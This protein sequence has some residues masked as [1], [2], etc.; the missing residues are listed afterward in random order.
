MS[1]GVGDFERDTRPEPAG[2]PGRYRV[3]L[4]SDWEVWGPNGGYMAA[5]ALRALAAESALPRPASFHCQ[6]L[7][8]GKFAPADV[9]V[10]SVRAG[11]R[12]EAL[13]CVVT[14]DGRP[15]VT[16]SGW[17]AADGMSAFAHVDTAAPDVPGPAELKGFQELSDDYDQWYP[18]WRSVEARPLLWSDDPPPPGPPI[19]RAWMRVNR[20]P[21]VFDAALA[22]ARVA[23]WADLGP[24]NAVCAAHEWPFRW[25][26]PNLDLH[27]QFHG[28]AADAE[29]LLID[30]H[31]PVAAD[32]LVGT[33][34]R[35]WTEDGRLVAS[36][37]SQLF[38]RRN[39][40]YE[41]DLERRA[42]M[43]RAKAARE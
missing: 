36:A 28:V 27:V 5:I 22:A 18:Y 15:L 32:G 25:L 11:Q 6:F 16:A 3:A 41:A 38:A 9:A 31:A 23:L 24:W 35:I 43:E 29:W 42:E 10:E 4:S 12:S 14:Q 26:A 1:A 2:E 39:P 30:T 21:A 8:P 40:G 34:I 13:R 37:G 20:P 33:T 7:A 17:M 19:W